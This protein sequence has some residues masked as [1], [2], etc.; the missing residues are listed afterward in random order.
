MFN[1]SALV[2]DNYL[3]RVRRHTAFYA[4]FR[5]WSLSLSLLLLLLLLGSR[6]LFDSP[7]LL[8]TVFIG[9]LSLLRRVFTPLSPSIKGRVLITGQKRCG[10][11]TGMVS[12]DAV[13]VIRNPVSSTSRY[14]QPTSTSPDVM[15]LS[16]A[17]SGIAR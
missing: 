1:T 12:A 13:R 17:L 6:C 4:A 8:R 11:N 16:S 9:S 10:L 7:S 3:C 15:S 2:S 5:C 14:L